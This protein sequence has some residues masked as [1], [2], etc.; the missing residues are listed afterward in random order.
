[1][2]EIPEL[3]PIPELTIGRAHRLICADYLRA[4]AKLIEQNAIDAFELAWNTTQRK[5]QGKIIASADFLT[6]PVESQFLANVAAY[7]AEQA[8]KIDLVD[9]TEELQEN[10]PDVVEARKDDPNLS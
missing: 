8:K 10:H 9:I 2:S 1:M 4:I 6:G 3:P 7:Q 5:P